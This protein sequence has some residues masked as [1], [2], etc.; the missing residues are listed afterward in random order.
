MQPD[1]PSPRFGD[2]WLAT[3]ADEQVPRM[4]V[5]SEG[6]TPPARRPYT[7]GSASDLAAASRDHAAELDAG[8]ADARTGPSRSLPPAPTVKPGQTIKSPDH[9]AVIRA[10]TWGFVWSHGDSNPGL[11]ACRICHLAC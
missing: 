6:T 10:L 9:K 4:I 8:P 5:S 1:Q 3:L 7:R 11:L 2:V